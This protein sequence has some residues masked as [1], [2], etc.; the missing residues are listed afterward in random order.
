MFEGRRER[1]V[2]HVR[3]VD[4]WEPMFGLPKEVIAHLGEFDHVQTLGEIPKAKDFGD[5]D[6]AW[7][8]DLEGQ[9]LVPV[10]HPIFTE[11][12]IHGAVEFLFDG[13]NGG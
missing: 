8:V 10:L 12:S 6:P 7:S 9:A 11:G 2:V 1:C 5:V 4:P 13:L 3:G